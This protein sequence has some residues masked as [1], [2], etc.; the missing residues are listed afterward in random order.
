M[1][2]DFGRCQVCGQTV[3]LTKRG[4]VVRHNCWHWKGLSIKSGRYSATCEGSFTPAKP[5][6]GARDE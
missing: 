2:A 4:L 3:G 6:K 1:E 5:V